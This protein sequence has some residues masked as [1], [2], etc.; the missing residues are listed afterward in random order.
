MTD[1]GAHLLQ[2]ILDEPADD[3]HR[4]VYADWL[5]ENGQTDREEFIRV[6]IELARDWGPVNDDGIKSWLTPAGERNYPRFAYLAKRERELLP[7][8][9]QWIGVPMSI[10]WNLGPEGTSGTSG[11][12]EPPAALFHRGFVA[13]VR[14]DLDDWC[15]LDGLG[16]HGPAIVKAAPVERVVLVD[17]EPMH[18]NYQDAKWHWIK[19]RPELEPA[20]YNLPFPLFT[21]LPIPD[22]NAAIAIRSY[23]S[24]ELANDGLS[25]ACLLLANDFAALTQ[26]L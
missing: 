2:A 15:G 7:L 4:L 8:A 13:E 22:G 10:A 1:D 20:G 26:P 18:G 23:D 14:C 11:A 5:E 17:R 25:V 3:T 12:T 9:R 6:Q 19:G 21:R 24:R 16:G